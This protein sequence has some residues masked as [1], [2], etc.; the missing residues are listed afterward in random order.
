MLRGR[1][2]ENVMQR[3]LLVGLALVSVIVSLASVLAASDAEAQRGRRARGR[4]GRG[5]AA[6]GTAEAPQSAAIAPA[7]GEL[8]W[9]MSPEETFNHLREQVDGAYRERITKAAR[10]D[11]ILE[12]RL[13]GQMLEETRRIRSSFV[14]FRGQASGWDTS[15]IRDEFTHGN[16]ESL[17]L[18]RDDSTHSQRYYFFINDRLWK[19]YQAFDASVFPGATFAQFSEAIQGRF[20]RGVS[21]SGALVEGRQPTQWVEWQDSTTRLRAIDQT[22]FYGFFCLVFEDKATLR[23]LPQLRTNTQQ[24]GS[25][26]HAMVDSVLRDGDAQPGGTSDHSEDAHAD[27]ADRLSGQVRRRA[28][29]PPAAGAAASGS[30]GGSGSTSSG[31]SSSGSSG[32]GS[33]G[34]RRTSSDDPFEGRDL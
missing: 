34:T 9:G 15:F 33:S 27:I 6:A 22:R 10:T 5:A 18:W 25:G 13:R 8:R 28:D 21:R 16:S 26:G 2:R 1:T 29:A 30:A 11:A 12:D 17:M 31:S 7:L 19:V 14:R 32:T 23:Q 24:A 3:R 20:G 4:R